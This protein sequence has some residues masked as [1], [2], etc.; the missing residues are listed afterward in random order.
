MIK[1][2]PENSGGEISEVNVLNRRLMEKAEKTERN[3]RILALMTFFFLAIFGTVPILVGALSPDIHILYFLL[4]LGL[5]VAILPAVAFASKRYADLLIEEVRSVVE[6]EIEGYRTRVERY[7]RANRELARMDRVKN[8]LIGIV[9]HELRAPLGALTSSLNALRSLGD[10]STAQ[11][12]EEL[13]LIIGRGANRL[14]R[15]VND[16]VDVTRIESGKLKINYSAVNACEIAMDVV[17]SFE[18]QFSEKGVG[19]VFND[20]GTLLL[21]SCDPARIEQV[22][23]NLV[24]NALRFTA[25]GQVLVSVAPSPDWSNTVFCV[26][27]SGPGVPEELRQKVFERFFSRNA[28]EEDDRQGLG[29]GLAISRGIVEAH[30][31]RIWVEGKSELIQADS[32]ATFC[33]EIPVKEH[34]PNYASEVIGP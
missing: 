20:P 29:L 18:D 33:F 9:S 14:S 31:G 6:E 12:R 5:Y 24:S 8:E 15:L 34:E 19:L 4:I 10:G 25:S 13:L 22:L 11:E 17:N 7:A 16:L 1:R 21:T 26:A 32:G 30:G 23:V 27:D 2:Q 3:I 28:L